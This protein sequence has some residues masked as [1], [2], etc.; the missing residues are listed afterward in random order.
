M[1]ILKIKGKGK[2]PAHIQIRDEHFTLI[3]YFKTGNIKKALQHKNMVSNADLIT[4]TL[5]DLP[6]GKIIKLETN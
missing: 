5:K 2:I 6:Y 1:Y 3:A 4:E